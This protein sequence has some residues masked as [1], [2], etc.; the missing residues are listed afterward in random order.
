MTELVHV[1]E[2]DGDLKRQI[3]RL[4]PKHLSAE[5]FVRIAILAIS[6]TPKLAKCTPM[7]VIDCLL[8]LSEI[9]LEPDGRRAYLIP[10]GD[11]C[12]LL[13]D[14]KGLVEL[15]MNNEKVSN[16][17]ADIV[18][19]NDV[20]VYDRGQVVQ[21]LIDFRKPRG[22]V[23]AAYATCR[24]KDGSEKSEVLSLDEIES[25]R[26]RSPNGN[27][28]PW[29]TDVNEMRK[30]T[31]ARRLSKWVPLSQAASDALMYDGDAFD[32]ISTMSEKQI[33]RQAVPDEPPKIEEKSESVPA[34]PPIQKKETLF[35]PPD[36]KDVFMELER[37][38]AVKCNG[39]VESMED[40]LM[41]ASMYNGNYVR[42]V[43]ELRA[44]DNTKRAYVIIKKLD[45]MDGDP[46]GR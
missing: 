42:T 45:Q 29:V 21:H 5:R 30:K 37:K 17:H 26:K 24:F 33:A 27:T 8:K 12:T 22:G 15:M 9:G 16:I 4:L 10:R 18:C 41:A 3:K 32:E 44:K 31:A 23:Y 13:L 40:M 36:N 39:D 35:D 19:D 43:D 14:Y 1:I 38:L 28:G 20:F 6:K 25:I 7:S 34:E 46:D 2:N 11:Q